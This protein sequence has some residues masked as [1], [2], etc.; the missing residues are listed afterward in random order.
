M[1]PP[2]EMRRPRLEG[3]GWELYYHQQTFRVN[4]K[5]ENRCLVAVVSV[6]FVAGRR[7]VKLGMIIQF[8]LEKIGMLSQNYGNRPWIDAFVKMDA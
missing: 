8:Y 2:K 3:S 6:P 5:K 4:S 1:G 7:E